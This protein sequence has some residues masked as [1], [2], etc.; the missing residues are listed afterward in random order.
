MNTEH[1]RDAEPAEAVRGDQAHRERAARE[2]GLGQ[3]V[4]REPEALGYL[5]DPLPGLGAQLALPVERLGGGAD[6]HASL[7]RHVTDGHP[8]H[9][10]SSG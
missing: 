6:G 8:P 9:L 5:G 2:Q 1:D 4:R 3:R 7:G 10:H